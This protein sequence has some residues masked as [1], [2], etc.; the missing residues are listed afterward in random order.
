MLICY[1][2]I[3]LGFGFTGRY[4]GGLVLGSTPATHKNSS[5]DIRST[6]FRPNKTTS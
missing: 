5:T 4:K 1:L 2:F 6:R 3:F